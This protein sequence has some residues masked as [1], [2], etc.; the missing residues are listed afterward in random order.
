MNPTPS[1]TLTTPLSSLDDDLFRQPLALFSSYL[2]P[3]DHLAKRL[4]VA[5]KS[6]FVVQKKGHPTLN[7]HP[8]RVLL[9]NPP[10]SQSVA[11]PM[12]PN[13]VS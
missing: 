11:V 2:R 7:H 9:G 12:L 8:G 6:L 1:L 4:I 10:K 5:R 3:S 13:F